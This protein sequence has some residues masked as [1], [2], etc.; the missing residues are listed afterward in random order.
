MSLSRG[1]AY[2]CQHSCFSVFLRIRRLNG[3][4]FGRPSRHLSPAMFFSRVHAQGGEP[5]PG[6]VLE[7]SKRA[8]ERVLEHL[9][10]RLVSF[11]GQLASV[12]LLGNLQAGLRWVC[13]R[14]GEVRMASF[15]FF[16]AWALEWFGAFR[17]SFAGFRGFPKIRSKGFRWVRGIDVAVSRFG[18]TVSSGWDCHSSF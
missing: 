9:P 6:S 7:A 10:A 18:Y 17:E 3:F 13:L 1:I 16:F 12:L 8:L 11:S 5:S 4:P 14:K 2:A 15:F